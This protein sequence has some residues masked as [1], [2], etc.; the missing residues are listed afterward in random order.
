MMS[1]GVS[2]P[3]PKGVH[4]SGFEAYL[5]HRSKRHCVVPSPKSEVTAATPSG[6]MMMISR[7]T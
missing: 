2:G 1:G 6:T 5:V 4:I 7:D 3:I